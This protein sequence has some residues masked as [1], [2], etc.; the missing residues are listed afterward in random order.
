M[1][2]I[3]TSI[4]RPVFAWILMSGL[5]IFGAVAAT[6]L[7]VSQLPDID[8]PILTVNVTYEALRPR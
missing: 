4:I 8:F 6:R 3:A 1:N 2:L 7:G 5:I